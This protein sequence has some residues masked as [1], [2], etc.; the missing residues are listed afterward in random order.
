MRLFAV[1][2]RVSQ[3]HYGDGT[4]T[5][6]NEYHTTIDFD[7]HGP[8]TFA[9]PLAKLAPSTSVAPVKVRATR[10]KKAV[11]APLA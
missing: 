4:V 9:T 7:T 8:R 2:D 11:A 10:R 5:S 1:G 6:S 3:S